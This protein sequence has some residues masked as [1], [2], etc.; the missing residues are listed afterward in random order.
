MNKHWVLVVIAAVFEVMWVAGLKHADN[1]MEWGLTVLAIVISFSGLIYSGKKLPTSTV[2]AI[3]VGLGTAG[4]VITEMVLFGVPFSWGKV[5][6]IVSLLV[7]II[8]LKLVTRNPEDEQQ[9]GEL[10]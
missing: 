7:G 5:W 10:S 4:T 6:L 2:Y 1:W 8:G 9:R 3:F